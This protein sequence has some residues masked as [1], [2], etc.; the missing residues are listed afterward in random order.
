LPP[1]ATVIDLADSL[2]HRDRGHLPGA[3]WA[4]RSRLDAARDRIGEVERV[5]LTSPDGVLAALAQPEAARLWPEAFVLAGGTASWKGPLEH[6][7]RRPTTTTDDLWYKP[8]DAE[9]QRVA[10]QHMQEYLRWEVALLEQISRDETVRF[11]EPTDGVLPRSWGGPPDE[12]VVSQTDQ[13]A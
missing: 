6:G 1:T 3:W 5:V 8:Y 13:R 7:L 10:R 4:V 12:A 9:N 2:H 11:A